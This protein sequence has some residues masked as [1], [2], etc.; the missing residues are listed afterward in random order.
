MTDER[1]EVPALTAEEREIIEWFR[2]LP[3]KER[4]KLLVMARTKDTPANKGRRGY[5]AGLGKV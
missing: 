1:N 3:V 5:Y 4:Q 2:T